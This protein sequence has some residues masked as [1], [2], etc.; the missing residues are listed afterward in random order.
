[1]EFKRNFQADLEEAFEYF[2][3]KQLAANPVAAVELSKATVDRW[4]MNILR[5][6]IY[7]LLGEKR[8]N[9]DE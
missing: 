5:K 3:A 9:E 6:P 7:E 8:A 4:V 1:M 2:K